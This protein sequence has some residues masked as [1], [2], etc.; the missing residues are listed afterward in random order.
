MNP[1]N[2]RSQHYIIQY[3]VKCNILVWELI[4]FDSL[5]MVFEETETHG[6]QGIFCRPVVGTL[7]F[8]FEP[9]EDK[10]HSFL[11]AYTITIFETLE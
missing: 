9:H 6:L 2:K 11:D 4:V 10:L 1:Y 8:D 3:I 5:R 7:E